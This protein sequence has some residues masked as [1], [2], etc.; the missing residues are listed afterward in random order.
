M[1]LS[2][3]WSARWIGPFSVKKILHPD[4]YVLE[5]G[6][7]VVRV[8]IRYSMFR[9]LRSITGTRRTCTCGMKILGCHPSM[10]FRTGR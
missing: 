6:K 10:N 3:K 9:Y 2:I 4:V 7:R 5:L 8:G 1:D